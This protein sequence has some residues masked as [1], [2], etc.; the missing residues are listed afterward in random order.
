[1]RISFSNVQKGFLIIA[2]LGIP[3][4]LSLGVNFF[5]GLGKNASFYPLFLGLLLFGGAVIFLRRKILIPKNP[6]YYLFVMFFSD[7]C[8]HNIRSVQKN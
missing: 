6:S 8:N 1:M 3:F 7:H 2:I 5:G 4:I